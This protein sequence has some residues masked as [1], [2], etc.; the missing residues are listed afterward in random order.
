M[1]L[2][3]LS[4]KGRGQN[5]AWAMLGQGSRSSFPCGPVLH[6]SRLDAW[7]LSLSKTL[8]TCSNRHHKEGSPSCSVLA[9]RKNGTVTD[10]RGRGLGT[11]EEQLAAVSYT[12]GPLKRVCGDRETITPWPTPEGPA[13]KREG[14]AKFAADPP[15][16]AGRPGRVV[17]S[18]SWFAVTTR[19][20]NLSGAPGLKDQ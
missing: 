12:T 8:S 16:A 5:R 6:H 4:L 7:Q 15:G 9:A 14:K 10:T 20:R 13:E 3:V 11:W 17:P 19:Q 1:A 2:L 18:E